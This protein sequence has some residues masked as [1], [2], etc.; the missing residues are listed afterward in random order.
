MSTD[1]TWHSE[2]KYQ[3]GLAKEF[4]WRK[5]FGYI[6]WDEKDDIKTEVGEVVLE[7]NGR[8]WFPLMVFHIS[9]AEV[10]GLFRFVSRVKLQHLR[11]RYCR[12]F[13]FRNMWNAC[14][15]LF[16]LVLYCILC[17]LYFS[18][19]YFLA[20]LFYFVFMYC[21]LQKYGVITLHFNY[22]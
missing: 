12:Y 1:G 5:L 4:W 2:G 17:L 13:H 19:I 16:Y 6:E 15:S 8:Y 11:V 20:Y 22:C 18:N 7:G 9:G 3:K 14:L 21:S 10:D